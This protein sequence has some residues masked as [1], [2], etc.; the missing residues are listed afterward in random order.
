MFYVRK[1]LYYVNVLMSCTYDRFLVFN[2]SLILKYVN[3]HP[4]HIEVLHKLT[5]AKKIYFNN[6]L[7]FAKISLHSLVSSSFYL[8]RHYEA[9]KEVR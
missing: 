5:L 3:N 4:P 7:I 8:I 6:V 9:L 2:I 1:V